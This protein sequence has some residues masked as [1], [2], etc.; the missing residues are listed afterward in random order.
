[1]ISHKE[2]K[3]EYFGACCRSCINQA[4]HLNLQPKDCEYIYFPNECR[5]CGEQK[6]IVTGIR[7]ISRWKLLRH[8]RS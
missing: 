3:K 1:M 6:N 4:C 2:M 8:V 5:I 7:M